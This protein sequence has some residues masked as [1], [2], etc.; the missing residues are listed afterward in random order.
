MA[1][2]ARPD[3]SPPKNEARRKIVENRAIHRSL[4]NKELTSAW[5]DGCH[6]E[7]RL[8]YPL[9]TQYIIGKSSRNASR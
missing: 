9:R 6:L 2:P 5:M 8:L 7:G 4:P 3:V 1:K